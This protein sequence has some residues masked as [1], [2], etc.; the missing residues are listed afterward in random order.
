MSETLEQEVNKPSHYNNNKCG[1]ETIEVTRYLGCDLGNAWKYLSRYLMKH[2][3]KKDLLKTIWY[4]EDFENHFLEFDN[5][6]KDFKP[7]VPN[8]VLGKMDKF[9]EA[10][11]VVEVQRMFKHI[12]S[13]INNDGIIDRELYNY[14]KKMLELYAEQLPES[15]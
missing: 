13:I 4:L 2:A 8:E 14:D 10:E 3:P 7:F 11:E 1:I 6:K 15:I 12:K 5:F 9:I